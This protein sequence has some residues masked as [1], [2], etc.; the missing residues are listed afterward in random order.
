[1][2]PW[3]AKSAPELIEGDEDMKELHDLESGFAALS[4]EYSKEVAA[5]LTQLAEQNKV[6]KEANEEETRQ[7]KKLQ[8]ERDKK[9]KKTEED[10]EAAIQA[11]ETERK[12]LTE[13]IRQYTIIY[14]LPDPDDEIIWEIKPLNTSEVRSLEESI[15]RSKGASK[16]QRLMRPG[17]YE[18]INEAGRKLRALYLYANAYC[19]EKISQARALQEANASEIRNKYAEK[20]AEQKR[21]WEKYYK[22]SDVFWSKKVKRNT[23]KMRQIMSSRELMDISRRADQLHRQTVEAYQWGTYKMP[24]KMPEKMRLANIRM[25]VPEE[26]YVDEK[27]F[28]P[29][30]YATLQKR[31]MTLPAYLDLFCSNII[32]VTTK[33][34]ASNPGGAA[35]LTALRLMAKMLQEIPLGY[36]DYHVVDVDHQ[37]QALGRFIALSGVDSELHLNVMTKQEQVAGYIKEQR[38]RSADLIREMAGRCK[39]LYEYNRKEFTHPFNWY[40]DLS[41]PEA[42]TEEMQKELQEMMKLAPTNGT[43][44]LFVTTNK[45]Y[46][47]I[48]KL[49]KQF[50]N[51]PVYHLDC[52]NLKCEMNSYSQHLVVEKEPTVD[53]L[54][55]FVD[56]V[57]KFFA[58][59]SKSDNRL[60]SNMSDIQKRHFAPFNQVLSLPFAMD[61]RGK[62]LEMK[63][64]GKDGVHGFISGDTGCGKSTLLH[65]MILSACRRYPP[66]DLQI[67]LVDYKMTDFAMYRHN[68]PPHIPFIGVSQAEEFTFGLLDK[69]EEEARR[70]VTLF[71]QFDVKDLGTY[72]THAG[73]PGYVNLPVLLVIIDEF[74]I[75]SQTVL[76]DSYY[77]DKLENALRLY[78]AHGIRF[79][80]ASQTFSKGLNGL[81]DAAKDQIGIRLA[82]R[83]KTLQDVKDSLETSATYT[84]A[85]KA[86]IERMDPGDIIM[87]KNIRDEKDRLVDIRLEK[88]KG[89]FVGDADIQKQ[90]KEIRTSYD[91]VIKV[92]D[93]LYINTNNQVPWNDKDM[94]ALD[95]MEKRR[96][97]EM[98][99][100]LGHCDMLRPCFGL[101]LQPKNSE[102]LSIVGGRLFQRWELIP[103]ILKSCHRN[104][105]KTH[106]FLAENC[107]LATDYGDELRDLCEQMPNVELHATYRDW[108]GNLMKL[109][110]LV[111]DRNTKREIM[112]LFLGL[113]DAQEEFEYMEDCDKAYSRIQTMLAYAGDDDDI[114]ISE[115]FD[116]M[117]LVTAMFEKGPR[118]GIHCVV[119][120]GSYDALKKLKG[121]EE[122]CRHRVA[123]HMS[124][125]D[126]LYYLGSGK[127]YAN[128]GNHAVCSSGGNSAPK[129]VPYKFL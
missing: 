85:M 93:P 72:R 28:E 2:L 1:M 22:D 107:D 96:S 87:A 40:M 117:P 81:S 58:E 27:G 91:K 68:T 101:D 5:M 108:C 39:T 44:F 114:I 26:V 116:A 128:I 36:T 99:L 86:E 17:H 126:C 49:A 46:N 83:N 42:P 124:V 13:R 33:G 123:F 119:E 10:L 51:I 90:L 75:M 67:W 88:Y 77:K 45:G 102:N 21:K 54:S 29:E 19:D 64:G 6:K 18:D 105:Y 115:E 66:T 43:S 3:N 35:N 47:A 52:S 30:C 76:N 50:T 111:E 57:K 69:I 4:L 82:M 109:A 63:L 62:L 70:R 106:V 23:D 9:I 118:R 122:K 20:I 15:A 37:G 104:G 38:E 60:A 32:V 84:D 100:Y 121:I 74:Q 8:Q 78:R 71:N 48:C 98:R 55:T 127:Y 16:L 112:C 89:L 95:Q 113:E 53:Q 94:D 14:N 65:S 61:S 59:G 79:L 25:D 92:P 125:D 7:I 103:A 129:L 12:P 24:E 110:D 41:F 120:S 97:T 31:P 11:A 80:L 56:A 73:E 34:N